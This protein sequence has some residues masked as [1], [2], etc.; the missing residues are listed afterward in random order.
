MM[1]RF[2]L[3]GIVVMAPLAACCTKS[4]TTA[5]P[6][7]AVASE[8]GREPLGEP[9]AEP[10]GQ[11]GLPQG[12]QS[13]PIA[14]SA[15]LAPPAVER[16]ASICAVIPEQER[17][18]RWRCESLIRY[19]WFCPRRVEQPETCRPK[20]DEGWLAC[21]AD[22]DCV[23]APLSSCDHCNGGAFLAVNRNF[24]SRFE[25]RATSCDSPQVPCT[26]LACETPA[27][28]ACRA[29]RC[30][31]VER[32]TGPYCSEVAQCET[33][34]VCLERSLCGGGKQCLPAGHRFAD[35]E[36]TCAIA[37]LAKP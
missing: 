9:H 14:A 25:K 34:E 31:A 11:E 21:G 37:P 3:L 28:V 33:G 5:R 8:T 16:K 6:R 30:A 26:E 10:Q 27:P 22:A 35:D 7:P 15:K 2:F 18:T 13:L 29:G 4:E 23:G 1:M 12:Q 36:T 17:A 19:P 24:V 20:I 32:P